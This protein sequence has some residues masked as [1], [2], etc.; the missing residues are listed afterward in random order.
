MVALGNRL[1]HLLPAFPSVTFGVKLDVVHAPAAEGGHV[2]RLVTQQPRATLWGVVLWLGVG[3]RVKV[4]V[5]IRV[6][7][8]A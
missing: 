5:R 2:L 6:R 3:V 4:R 8:R 1:V 7:V